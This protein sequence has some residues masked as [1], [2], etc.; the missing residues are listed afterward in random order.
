MKSLP[1]VIFASVVL[2]VALSFWATWSSLHLGRGPDPLDQSPFLRDVVEPIT[3]VNAMSFDDGG[4][5]PSRPS[6]QKL[7]LSPPSKAET[8]FLI[9]LSGLAL[10]FNACLTFP[11]MCSRSSGEESE[12]A[13]STKS[14]ELPSWGFRAVGPRIMLGEFK[15]FG[16][17]PVVHGRHRAFPAL[18]TLS[19]RFVAARGQRRRQT[20]EMR[21]R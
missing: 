4:E 1:R 19:S 9:R 7:R 2:A 8:N 13:R 18:H 12:S 16:R 17:S 14:N 3:N 11:T 10:A 6:C 20:D 15:Y 21:A 5:Y